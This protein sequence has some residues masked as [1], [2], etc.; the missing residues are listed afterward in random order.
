MF[1]YG[2]LTRKGGVDPRQ[3]TFAVLD[4]ETTGLEPDQG[5]R[6]CEIGIVRMRGD[7]TILDEYATLVNPGVRITNEELHEITDADVAHAPTFDQIAGDVLA[8]LRDAIVVSHYLEFEE[9]FLAAEFRRLGVNLQ[10]V[11]GLCTLVT[12]QTQLDRRGYRGG[13]RMATLAHL[14]TGE[15][16]VAQHSAL[17]DA[18][19][20]ATMLTVLL[21]SAPQPL[22]WVGPAPVPLPEL[23]RGG[24]IAPRATWLRKGREGW[25]ATLTARLPRMANPPPPRPKGL[26]D[27]RALLSHA[28]ADG[29]V[30][31]EE[32]RQLA[33]LAAR[34]GLTQ[35]TARKVH[36]DFLTEAR[37]RA[38]ADGIVTSAE[39]RELQRAAKELA[40][41]HLISDLEQAAAVRRAKANGPLKGWRILPVG[42]SAR[43]ARV[44]D[45]A[46]EHGAQIAVNLTKTVRLVVCDNVAE[47]NPR[48]AK[49]RDAGVMVLPP[50]E[51]Q[52]L[53]E[54]E[55]ADRAGGLFTD[56]AGAQVAD[57]LTAER[58]TSPQWY[59]FWRPRELTPAEY[60]ERFVKPYEGWDDDEPDWDEEPD[61]RDEREL[62][63]TIPAP[64]R[65]QPARV[66]VAKKP[67][68]CAPVL[69]LFGAVLV[70]IAELIRQL[71][72]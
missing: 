19:A 61:S 2:Q 36:E 22:F 28:L 40:A 6:V 16:P 32:A 17:G 52:K 25:L 54:A 10:G 57:Q 67:G 62:R 70:G 23:P 50:D 12:A 39:L 20:L 30:V 27:Y 42:E 1:H 48:L 72:A 37:A 15:W 44:I 38:E 56:P 31:G 53:L 60:H 45:F 55:V 7:G 71:V 68:G 65:T 66:P 34:A 47:E 29:R 4:L 24:P 59:S 49:A 3:L 35:T 58:T 21:T 51:A 14:V 8:Y 5:A 69:V 43:V 26:R 46:A 13:Y 33:V 64:P 41:T 18:R 9:K 11:P 63:I